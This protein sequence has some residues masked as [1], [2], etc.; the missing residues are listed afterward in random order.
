MNEPHRRLQFNPSLP[1]RLTRNY[2]TTPEPLPQDLIDFLGQNE[3]IGKVTA[4]M[5]W[6]IKAQIVGKPTS[7]LSQPKYREPFA[8]IDMTPEEG[9]SQDTLNTT[10]FAQIGKRGIGSTSSL[11]STTAPYLK[12][13]KSEKSLPSL[14]KNPFYSKI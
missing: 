10:V 14:T 1:D 4:K 9:P 3:V 7:A 6:Q 12:T 8:E 2:D 11:F 5:I 13:K